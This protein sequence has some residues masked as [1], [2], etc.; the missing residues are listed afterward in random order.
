[1]KKIIILII[2]MFSITLT[3]LS[4]DV[5]AKSISD[6]LVNEFVSNVSHLVD[7]WS[8]PKIKKGDTIYGTDDKEVGYLYRIYEGNKQEGYVLY[9][10]SIGIAEATWEGTDSAS[11]I[12]GKVYYITPG[13]FM[14]KSEFRK[15]QNN[16]NDS[17]VLLGDNEIGS[18]VY[19]V[20]NGSTGQMST[21]NFS[22]DSSRVPSLS[23]N[24]QIMSGPYAIRRTIQEVPD[25]NW[26]Y[27][28]APTSGGM[29]VA[30]YDNQVWDSLSSYDGNDDYTLTYE[31]VDRWLLSDYARNYDVVDDLIEELASSSYFNTNSDGGTTV[32]QMN[33][34]LENY[35]ADN[36]LSTYKVYLGDFQENISDYEALIR[37]G[38]TA[39][40]SMF[41][42]PTYQ[43]HGVL[44]MG[45]LL[46][47]PSTMG[48]I[49]HDTWPTEDGY[50]K[51]IFISYDLLNY[52]SF[53]YN[54]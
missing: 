29:L 20:T 51:E 17:G 9:L 23:N 22:F 35:F 5:S 1:M 18:T 28:C 14:S 3:T 7:T 6:D 50:P 43:N 33:V 40:I 2:F 16:Q 39:I 47:A 38:N 12:K 42:H 48:A 26:S 10:N 52:Y 36:G 19:H 11:G 46:A 25:Y 27:G 30:Y 41:G 34:G 21:I 8:N 24:V 44:G 32:A 37:S 54:D 31:W 4:I 13:L 49:V 15:Y 53:I 45:Y